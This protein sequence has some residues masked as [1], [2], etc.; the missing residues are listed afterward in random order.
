MMMAEAV[1]DIASAI[2]AYP[3]V[4]LLRCT[5]TGKR[6]FPVAAPQMGVSS[7]DMA[8]SIDNSGRRS[9]TTN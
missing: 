1:F 3:L 6:G 9:D 4:A 7:D 2:V 8:F 5:L